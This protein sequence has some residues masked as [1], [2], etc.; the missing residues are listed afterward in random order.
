MQESAPAHV[1]EA[2]RLVVDVLSPDELRALGVAA[3]K[4][5]Q[6]AD[7]RVVA[8][9]TSDSLTA[10]VVRIFGCSAAMSRP[11]SATTLTLQEAHAWTADGQP[12]PEK[13]ASMKG[14]NAW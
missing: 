3:R 10:S 9:T 7:P 1:R 8:I 11:S 12:T 13:R 4:I 2:R 14:E 6:L 5:I